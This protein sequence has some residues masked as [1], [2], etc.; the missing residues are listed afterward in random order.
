MNFGFLVFGTTPPASGLA[1]PRYNGVGSGHAG[2][3]DIQAACHTLGQRLAK[4]TAV[5]IDGR[6]EQ[7]PLAQSYAR[8]PSE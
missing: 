7:R 3:P 1:A 6:S 4:W 5:M 2:E 8:M